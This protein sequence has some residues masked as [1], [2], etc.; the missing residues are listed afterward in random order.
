ML[1][2]VWLVV[3][4]PCRTYSAITVDVATELVIAAAR[5]STTGKDARLGAEV[6][7]TQGNHRMFRAYSEDMPPGSNLSGYYT[8][9]KAS[10]D[11]TDITG[12]RHNRV[13]SSSLSKLRAEIL[14]RR[15]VR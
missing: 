8:A 3:V 2:W 5:A 6:E 13:R 14:K 11:V 15:Y 1:L 9:S 10:G 12:E 7:E 4:Q